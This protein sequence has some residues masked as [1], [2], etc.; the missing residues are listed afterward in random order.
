VK[1][2]QPAKGAGNCRY[3]T[4]WVL[5]MLP[6]YVAVDTQDL[7]ITTT[8]NTALQQEASLCLQGAL[9]QHPTAHQGAVL[10]FDSSGAVKAFVGGIDYTQSQFNR[11]LALRSGGSAFKLF[12]YLAALEADMTPE[13]R[14]AD[15][16]V[17]I[18]KWHPSL[19]RWKPRGEIS[20]KEAFAY[21][22]NPVSVR[23]ARTLGRD[24]IVKMARRLG[25]STRQPHDLTVALGSG[26]VTLLELSGAYATVCADGRRVTPFAIREITD[27]HGLVLYRREQKSVQVI[28]RAICQKMKVLLQA[29]VDY[30]TGKRAKLTI[31][32]FGKTGT[33]NDSRD[34][35][36]VG[37]AEGV[38][39][40]V[41]IGNDDRRPMKDV[42]GGKLPAEIWRR[43]MQAVLGGHVRALPGFS[44][45]APT[46]DDLPT[47][48][49]PEQ[50]E[51]D[52]NLLNAFI[53]EIDKD[54]SASSCKPNKPKNDS[55]SIETLLKE[56][57]E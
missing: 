48:G 26:E 38:T 41:W 15:T 44:E 31:P 40:A 34:A 25:I 23:I 17:T 35:W 47:E 51:R 7:L 53:E 46:P 20:L 30:G 6:E 36:F 5:E 13:T 19:F 3:F 52:K 50:S 56:L 54:Q 42:T 28:A 45:I 49:M 43:F 12:V 39:T 55:T 14:I 1:V 24:R 37:T 10:C 32:T 21:S 8:L 2:L 22:V 29:V 18:G 16:P 27:C 4:D 9:H 11:V 57:D 33:S